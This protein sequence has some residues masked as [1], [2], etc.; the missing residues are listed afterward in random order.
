MNQ[1][2]SLLV[3]PVKD[4]AK[5]RHA[6]RAGEGCGRQHGRPQAGLTLATPGP[7][8]SLGVPALAGNGTSPRG[9]GGVLAQEFGR[10]ALL[11]PGPVGGEQLSQDPPHRLDLGVREVLRE[12]LAKSRMYSQA[13]R[14]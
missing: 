2:I 5:A 4:I 11:G 10:A 8:P 6:H 13:R 1:G 12:P 14:L 3:Y 9:G 7:P